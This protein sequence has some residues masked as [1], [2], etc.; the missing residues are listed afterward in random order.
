MLLLTVEARLLAASMHLKA[1]GAEAALAECD[2]VIATTCLAPR[3]AEVARR[4]RS[5]ALAALA[6]LAPE[7]SAR[8]PARSP[9]RSSRVV[10][11]SPL[12][13]QPAPHTPRGR[14]STEVLLRQRGLLP[15]SPA[16]PRPP[17][18]VV[19]TLLMREAHA[20]NEAGEPAL[21]G[22]LFNASYLLTGRLEARVSAANM[23]LKLGE[24]E[25]ALAEYS[26]LLSEGAL[27]EKTRK[28]VVRK[29]GEAEALCEGVMRRSSLESLRRDVASGRVAM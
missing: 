10:A 18:D 8:S 20:A 9:A 5:Q 4:K 23:T 7:P 3:A 29:A 15:V 17:G 14:S 25:A 11:G 2:A 27:S 13:T 1:G 6:A 12:R 22:E 26:Q 19:S 16:S 24:A 21:A 28:V